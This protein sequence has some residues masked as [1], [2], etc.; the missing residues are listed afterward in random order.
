MVPSEQ[1]THG[2][3]A[4]IL[5]KALDAALT[6]VKPNYVQPETL[7]RIAD[8]LGITKK[9]DGKLVAKLKSVQQEIDRLWSEVDRHSRLAVKPSFLS[10]DNQVATGKL[11]VDEALSKPE[12][13][14]RFAN[15]RAASK[16]AAFALS[17]ECAPDCVKLADVFA[18]ACA[19]EVDSLEKQERTQAD[20]FG[21][22]HAA[23][24]VVQALRAAASAAPFLAGKQGGYG[25]PRQRLPWLSL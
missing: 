17:I 24:P 19:A 10:Q 6:P 5:S 18:A 4:N 23:S 13:L 2:C 3:M 25:Q 20:K 8:V 16:K 14:A 9:L 21:V 12:I 7:A 15:V 11:D 1:T 22:E